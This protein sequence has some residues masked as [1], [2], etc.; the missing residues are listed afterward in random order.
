LSF[1]LKN[2]SGFFYAMKVSYQSRFQN[3]FNKPKQKI[4][5]FGS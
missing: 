2:I 4:S 1:S 3:F 5:Y